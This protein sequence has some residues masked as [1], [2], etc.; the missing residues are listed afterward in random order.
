[1]NLRAFI[2]THLPRDWNRGRSRVHPDADALVF[3]GVLLIA[4]AT[5]WIVGP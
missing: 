4:W 1:M 2:W 5:V 3:L